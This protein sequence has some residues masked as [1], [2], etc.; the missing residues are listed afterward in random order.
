MAKVY[1]KPFGA[2]AARGQ[3]P[4]NWV[5][6]HHVD[7]QAALDSV[8]AYRADI[9]SQVLAQ[10]SRSGAAHIV[11]ERNAV[12]RFVALVDEPDEYGSVNAMAIETGSSDGRGGVH[13]LGHAF[14]ETRVLEL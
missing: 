8:A 3:D 13:A 10:H 7:V 5:I 12:D 1:R 9:A 4:L 14:P 11:V 2:P 6:S